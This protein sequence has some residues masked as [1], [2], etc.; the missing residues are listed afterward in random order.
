[1]TNAGE[2]EK[3]NQVTGFRSKNAR[4]DCTRKRKKR[5]DE[6]GVGGGKKGQRNLELA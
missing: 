2:T 1:L 5:G 6:G 3:D 4:I